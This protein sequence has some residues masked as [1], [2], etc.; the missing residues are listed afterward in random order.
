[1]R[2]IIDID[3]EIRSHEETLRDLHQQVVGG[4]EIVSLLYVSYSFDMLK[5]L[6]ATY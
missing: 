4:E 1:M 3:V 5:S 2:E 6:R